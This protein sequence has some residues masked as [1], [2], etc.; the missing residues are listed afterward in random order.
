MEL[1]RNFLLD[2]AANGLLSTEQA[3]ELWQFSTRRN[4]ENPNVRMTHVLYYLGG[5]IAIGAMSLF[6]NEGWERFGGWGL[7]LIAMVYAGFGLG[8]TEYFLHHKKQPIPAGIMATF[9]VVMTPLAV[10][11]LQNALGFWDGTRIYRDYHYLIDWRWMFMELATL[12]SGAIMLWRYRLP[13][14]MMPIAVTLWY[15]SMDLAQFIF[16]PDSSWEM[17]RWLSLWFGVGMTFLA[18]W[19]DIRSSRKKDYSYWLYLF[20]VLTFWGGLS[21]LKSDS[22]LGRFGYCCINVAMILTSAMLSRGV[23]AVFGGFGVAFYLGHLS[24]R[25]FAGS[26][27]FPFALTLIGFGVIGA[28]VLWQRYEERIRAALRAY[29]PLPL[30]ELGGR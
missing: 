8:M 27:L 19:I 23:F 4:D 14:M 10:Y 17:R 21:L 7:F 3:K 2:A 16:G 22:E 13:F 30:Q 24:Y 5:M 25:V 11:G 18:V 1:T 20:G 29:L 15:M 9:V 26:L 12:A 6:M 28:G